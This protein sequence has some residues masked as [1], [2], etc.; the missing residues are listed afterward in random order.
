MTNSYAATCDG[1]EAA[2][3][4]R[5]GEQTYAEEVQMGRL[6]VREVR[7]DSL[8]AALRL[9]REELLVEIGH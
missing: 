7:S 3:L 6:W 9:L 8:L 5:Q 1:A 4:F 2:R